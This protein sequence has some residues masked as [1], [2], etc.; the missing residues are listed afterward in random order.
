MCYLGQNSL[1]G[2]LPLQ[3][4]T[5]VGFLG[6][7]QQFRN[8]KVKALS[9]LSSYVINPYRMCYFG[10]TLTSHSTCVANIFC[11][12]SIG[13]CLTDWVGPHLPFT[14]DRACNVTLAGLYTAIQTEW[15]GTPMPVMESQSSSLHCTHGQ[16]LPAMTPW[17]TL[18]AL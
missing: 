3:Y 1:C 8:K 13:P 11:A 14:S 17:G 2:P 16:A 15:H 18:H 10:K 6:S 12:S 4:C 9:I 7:K 5:F